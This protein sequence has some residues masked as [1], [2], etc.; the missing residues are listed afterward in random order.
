VGRYEDCWTI[1]YYFNF[2]VRNRIKKRKEKKPFGADSSQVSGKDS[3]T[4]LTSSSSSSTTTH[5][6][7]IQPSVSP[8]P[9]HRKLE[10]ET[11]NHATLISSCFLCKS[12]TSVDSSLNKKLAALFASDSKIL[13]TL[14]AY[15]IRLNQHLDVLLRLDDSLLER[16]IVS[17]PLKELGSSAKYQLLVLL[18]RARANCTADNLHA[19]ND[20]VVVAQLP[21]QVHPPVDISMVS[22]GIRKTLQIHGLGELVPAFA[23]MGLFTEGDFGF[24]CKLNAYSRASLIKNS[25]VQLSHFQDFMLNLAFGS[26]G[27]SPFGNI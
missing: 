25:K 20:A 19:F 13:Q 4:V 21:C 27:E 7:T 12:P 2:V 3:R 16:L 17:I 15:G 26:S 14:A 24:F 5:T 6:N 10:E 9:E 1:E 22:S 8:E 23:V 18:E 11:V